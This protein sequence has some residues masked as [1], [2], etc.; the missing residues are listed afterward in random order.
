[1]PP[2]R[3]QSPSYLLAQPLPVL[4]V[5]AWSGTPPHTFTHPSKGKDKVVPVLFLIEH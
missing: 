5:A 1:M 4:L 2:L 3:A